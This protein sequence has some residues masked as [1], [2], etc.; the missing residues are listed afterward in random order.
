M[1]VMVDDARWWWRE[2]RWAHLAS[3]GGLDELHRFAAGLGLHR[4]S[5]GGDHYDVTEEQRL[6]ALAAGA[7]PVTSRDLVRRLRAAGLRRAAATGSHRWSRAG[8]LVWD[9]VRPPRPADLAGLVALI[10]DD[11]GPAVTAFV[12]E[13]A[14]C[15]ASEPFE[16]RVLRRPPE[17]ALL[18]TDPSDRSDGEVAALSLPDPPP[19]GVSGVWLTAG[20]PSRLLEVF[21]RRLDVPMIPG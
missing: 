15:W 9:P 17:A 8:S 3:D 2:R 6:A 16:L 14:A 18:L 13:V 21:I 19:H 4:V 7:E 12:V 11:P 10:G 20:A 5:F 1:A